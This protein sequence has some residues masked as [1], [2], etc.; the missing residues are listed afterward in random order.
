MRG[1]WLEILVIGGGGSLL[2]LA[3]SLTGDRRLTFV[4]LAAAM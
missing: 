1:V 4:G 2:F 3:I